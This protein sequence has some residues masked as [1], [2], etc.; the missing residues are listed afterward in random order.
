MTGDL[1]HPVTT[2]PRARILGEPDRI[3]AEALANAR[4]VDLAEFLLEGGFGADDVR[5]ITEFLKPYMVRDS[6]PP[7]E[8][9]MRAL[10]ERGFDREMANAFAR[11]FEKA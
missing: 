10:T 4:A 1:G 9:T 2:G 7:Y 5:T 8:E 11:A 6:I 3:I